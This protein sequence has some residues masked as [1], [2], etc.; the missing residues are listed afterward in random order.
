MY[1]VSCP[2]NSPKFEELMKRGLYLSHGDTVGISETEKNTVA[3]GDV[4]QRAGIPVIS[5]NGEV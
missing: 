5:L 4:E 1:L 2:R 3:F